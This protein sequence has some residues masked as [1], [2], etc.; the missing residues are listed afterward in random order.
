[1]ALGRC[2][3]TPSTAHRDRAAQHWR[4]DR[5]VTCVHPTQLLVCLYALHYYM[6]C[7]DCRM[8][9]GNPP[10]CRGPPPFCESNLIMSF[11]KKLVGMP[12]WVLG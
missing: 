3:L 8:R 7:H 2:Y 9:T 5:V 6:T 11:R 1:M 12:G 10:A 4:T